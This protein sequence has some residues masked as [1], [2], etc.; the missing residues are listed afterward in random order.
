MSDQITYRIGAQFN[1]R[2]NLA[3]KAGGMAKSVGDLGSKLA[4]AGAR[5]SAFGDRML[6][7]STAAAI[8]WAKVG[9]AVGSAA[10]LGGAAAIAKAGFEGNVGAERLKSTVAGTLQLFNHSAGAADQL[11][12]N[13]K[14]A[15]AAM[16]R[17]NDIADSSPGELKD[18]QQ[19]FQNMLPGARAVTGDMQRI[20]DLT[21]SAA[22]FTPTFGGDFGMAGSQ[23]SRILTGGAGAEMETWKILQVPILKAGQA[24]DLYGQKGKKVFGENQA[25]GE[26]L[27]QAF[28]KLS[29]VDRLNLVEA[30]MKGGADD[31][32]KMY[33]NSW[34]GASASAVSAGRKV[35]MAF[36][37]PI[38]G[39]V[40]KSLIR[41]G[42]QDN[43]LL[44]KNRINKMIGQ[45]AAIGALMAKPVSRMLDKLERGIRYFQDN[46]G[47]VFNRMYQ[48]M[49]IGAGLLRA[50]F[51]FGLAKMMAGAAITAASG[52]VRAGRGLVG[53]AR[54]IGKNFNDRRKR[55]GDGAV[56]TG[57][58]MFFSRMAKGNPLILAASNGF[59]SMGIG[60]VSMI[61]MLLIAAA[62]LAIFAIPFL[63]IAG[64]AAYV[65]SKWEELSASIVKGF[66][67]GSI[68]IKPLVIAVL[69]LWER[70]KKLG[71][72]FIGGQTGATMMQKAINMA[73]SIVNGLSEGVAIMA[74]V[75]A[76]MLT[77]I[78]KLANA[79]QDVFGE[80][81]N[82]RTIARHKEL[83]DQGM[84]YGEAAKRAM[85]E[86][87]NGFHTRGR[88]VGDDAQALA[89]KLS[90]AAKSWRSVTIDSLDT[91]TV[92]SWTDWATKGLKD[93]FAGD[94][95]DPK[96]KPKGVSIGT[97]II[98]VD[99]RNTDPDRMMVGLIEPIKKATKQPD[100]SSF[101]M[102][103][104]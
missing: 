11:G 85:A 82:D 51:A 49:Q 6:Q 102:G 98:Q 59:L 68:T 101:D 95:E 42:S 57:I 58:G 74:T 26:K 4:A 47:A 16:M 72:A 77:I 44:G 36:T 13:I 32:A 84:S 69:V 22:V 78:G 19:L 3:A 96:K 61:P 63:A 71:E 91:S 66:Q 17:L 1:A 99:L 43:S 50:A 83:Q 55:V 37:A 90:E 38:F 73:T 88:T 8:G 40:K 10:F 28:N 53:G 81:D 27:T 80:T 21:K 30:S 67:D 14:V 56:A 25:E 33:A 97:A 9:A 100:S 23:L 92:D 18:V 86:R 31:L 5:A 104:F 35:S 39:E 7:S 45:A 24:M 87:A 41:A 75:A 76:G 65:A 15:E 62:A 89:D 103:G 20:L 60:L 46:F 48:V 12:T 64:I 93:L 94:T 54:S 52:A 34:E 29:K 79:W 70:L 2:G